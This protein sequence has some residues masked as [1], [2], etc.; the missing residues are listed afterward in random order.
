MTHRRQTAGLIDHDE[1]IV[2]ITAKQDA[3]PALPSCLLLWGRVIDRAIHRYALAGAY[4]PFGV[5]TQIPATVTFCSRINR[6]TSLSGS[7]SRARNHDTRNC[8][9]AWADTVQSANSHTGFTECGIR[10]GRS[11]RRDE[12]PPVRL[13]SPFSVPVDGDSSGA[14]VSTGIAMVGIFAPVVP[15]SSRR[16][17][18]VDIH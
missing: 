14:N 10:M 8:P 12:P 15:Q 6:R 4:A 7:D 9:L 17:H 11:V 5:A 16:S 13:A 1:M 18:P 2:H 3:T